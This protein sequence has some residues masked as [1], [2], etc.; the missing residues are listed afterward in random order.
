MNFEQACE[1]VGI[2][3]TKRQKKKFKKGIGLA[4]KFQNAQLQGTPVQKKQQALFIN[5]GSKGYGQNK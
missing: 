2:N 4:F 5:N 3:S 1:N